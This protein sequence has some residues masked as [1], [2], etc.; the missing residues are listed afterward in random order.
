MVTQV[1]FLIKSQGQKMKP[2]IL[3][4]GGVSCR[5]F[6]NNVTDAA[7]YGGEFCWREMMTSLSGKEA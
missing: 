1:R 7:V 2:H 4:S 5:A 6:K 3:C